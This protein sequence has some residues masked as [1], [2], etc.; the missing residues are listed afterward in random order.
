MKTKNLFYSFCLVIIASQNLFSQKLFFTDLEYCLTHRIDQSDTY[1]A[2]KGYDFMKYNEK[3]NTYSCAYTEWAFARN[4]NNNRAAAFITKHCDEPN[5]GFVWF[6]PFD[7][8][9]FEAIK[10]ECLLLGFKFKTKIFEKEVGALNFVYISKRYKIEFASG[11]NDDNT[12]VYSIT[13]HK[14]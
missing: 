14:L 7:K 1:L 8:K 12:N 5:E 11:I 2:K 9:T 4:T 13:L 6:Q 10:T 3:E